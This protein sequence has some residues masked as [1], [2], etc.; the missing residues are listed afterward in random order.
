MISIV[1]ISNESQSKTAKHLTSLLSHTVNT[2]LWDVELLCVISARLSRPEEFAGLEAFCRN[3]VRF[4]TELR[5]GIYAAMNVGLEAASGCFV[6][7]INCGDTL[8]TLP[9]TMISGKTNCFPVQYE[10]SGAVRYPDDPAYLFPHHQ[11]TFYPEEVYRSSRFD[12]RLGLVGDLDYYLRLNPLSV[13]MFR[14]PVVAEFELGGA[15][16]KPFNRFQRMRERYNVLYR[17]KKLFK[18]L[19]LDVFRWL[20]KKGVTS[21]GK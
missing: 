8:L 12:E 20:T 7:F 9:S 21:G 4:V 15:S 10:K 11:G 18:G 14:H 13:A 2:G 1:A 16:M 5:K 19:T 3:G 17:R 6:V